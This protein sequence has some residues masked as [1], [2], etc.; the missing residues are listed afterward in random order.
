[1]AYIKVLL[2]TNF[3]SRCTFLSGRKQATEIGL[4]IHF[5]AFCSVEVW[6]R[7]CI[8][9]Q[10]LGYVAIPYISWEILTRCR[11]EILTKPDNCLLRRKFFWRRHFYFPILYEI[12]SFFVSRSFLKLFNWKANYSTCAGKSKQCRLYW[13]F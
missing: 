12:F 7:S 3:R 1:M 2:K 11:T 6:I 4:F 9:K 5:F 8:Y 13:Q 10:M